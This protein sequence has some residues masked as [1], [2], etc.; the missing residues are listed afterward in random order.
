MS[1]LVVDTDVASFMFKHSPAAEPYVDVLANRR[2]VLSFM[3]LAEL[4]WW[5]T[6]AHWGV[7]RTALL[8][9]F[10]ESFTVVHSDRSLCE[11][12]ADVRADGR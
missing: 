7:R 11:L 1:L 5:Q 9:R 12:W 2:L 6:K 8:E 3:T 4:R 10:L